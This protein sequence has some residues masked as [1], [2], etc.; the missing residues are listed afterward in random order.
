MK[1]NIPKIPALLL[2]LF[3]T[4]AFEISAATYQVGDTT[5]NFSFVARRQFTRHDGVVVPAGATV[6]LHDLAGRIVFLEWF[7]VWCP[8]CVAAAPQVEAGIVDH[9]AARGGNPAGIP[10]LHIAVNQEPRSFYQSQT[11]TFINDQGFRVV[12]NDYNSTSTNRVR[13][14]FQSSGQP[15][16]A[17]INGV[18]NSPSHRPWQV[19][20]N[21]LG[22]GETDFNVEL[23]NFRAAIDRVRLP[24]VAP[25]LTGADFAGGVFEFSFQ[26]QSSNNYRVDGSTNLSSWTTVTNIS[27]STNRLTI[28]DSTA[29]PRRFYRVVVP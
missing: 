11:D 22:Y 23:A 26:A 3:L 1:K 4:S 2:F 27:T 18:T 24:A 28:R 10:V 29:N 15:I 16:F 17:V 25:Q 20:V 14:M 5:T 19:L 7:A 13:F 21:H 9:Y 8:F 6:R 12:V